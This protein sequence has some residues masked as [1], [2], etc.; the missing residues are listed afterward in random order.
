M[1]RLMV[2]ADR[3]V[4]SS[5]IM[6]TRTVWGWCKPCGKST[7]CWEAIKSFRCYAHSSRYQHIL[8]PRMCQDCW[9]VEEAGGQSWKLLDGRLGGLPGSLPATEDT[10][11]VL[12]VFVGGAERSCTMRVLMTQGRWVPGRLNLCHE[13]GVPL[14]SECL[15]DGVWNSA[16]AVTNLAGRWSSGFVTQ[17][18]DNRVQRRHKSKWLLYRDCSTDVTCR[19]DI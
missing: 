11:C 6:K 7:A 13:A 9:R 15:H 4:A 12:L 16:S 10:Q 8:A 2:E 5:L 18:S 14:T 3:D 17:R 1:Q 19:W